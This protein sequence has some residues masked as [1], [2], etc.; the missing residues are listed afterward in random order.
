MTFE[1]R[2]VP[3]DEGAGRFLPWVIAVMAFLATL[4][5]AGALA[6]DIAL[7]NWQSGL[8][9]SLTIEVP[10]ARQGEAPANAA[11]E[12]LRQTPGIKSV[13][14]LSEQELAKLLEPWLGPKTP[15]SD[16]PVPRLIDVELDGAQSL[17]M[18]ALAQQLEE[19]VPGTRIDD[20]K[21]W[22]DHLIA[23]ARGF[24]ALAATIVVLIALAMATVVVF[25][26]RAALAAHDPVVRLLHQM[27][28]QDTFIAAQFQKHALMMGLRGGLIGLALGALAMFL[29]ARLAAA[30]ETPMLPSFQF[31]A[32]TLAALALVP[33]MSGVIAF[34]TARL[35][36]L[37][38]LR[39]MP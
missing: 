17:D 28:A 15:V 6:L 10:V 26:I 32:D 35:T 8:E 37:A 7:G 9:G 22:L 4:A 33:L 5:T 20:H 29:L 13:R 39:R 3:D 12:I 36:V 25:A 11:I 18:E 14:L 30:I 38:A 2:L 1:T 31:R 19:R 24:Q 16:L 21:L 34:A 27:G 23:L